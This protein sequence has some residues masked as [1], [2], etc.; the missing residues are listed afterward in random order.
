M[1]DLLLRIGVAHR[2]EPSL[3]TLLGVIG[4]EYHSVSTTN[5]TW[6]SSRIKFSVVGY[7]KNLELFH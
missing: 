1:I 7:N 5:E 4:N 2:G 3:N 6:C